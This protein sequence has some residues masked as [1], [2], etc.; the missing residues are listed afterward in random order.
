MT[1]DG[2]H[3]G[4]LLRHTS[5]IVSYEAPKFF[6]DEMTAGMFKGFRHDH[7]F[8]EVAGETLMQDVLRFEAP[9]GWLGVLTEKLVLRRYF[10]GFLRE[11][12]AVI[13]QVVESEEWRKYL[14]S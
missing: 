13:K 8:T 2:R 4:F 14:V 10:E 5:K 9:L 6:C 7:Y 3:F 11:R 1:W 12:N